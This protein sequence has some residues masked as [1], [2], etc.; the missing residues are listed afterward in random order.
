[1]AARFKQS[2]IDRILALHEKGKT[3]RQIAGIVRC[4]RSAVW[5][6]IRKSKVTA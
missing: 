3:E 4:S 1:M 6:H 5:N 2:K